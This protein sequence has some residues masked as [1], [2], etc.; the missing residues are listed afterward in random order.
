MQAKCLHDWIPCLKLH[1]S[2]PCPKLEGQCH[3]IFDFPFGQQSSSPAWCSDSQAIKYC[4]EIVTLD[5]S[6][7]KKG[8]RCRSHTNE[9]QSG[10][11]TGCALNYALFP[12]VAALIM[13]FSHWMRAWLGITLIGWELVYALFSLVES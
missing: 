12:L 3:K 10:S 7:G 11:N 8:M 6:F 13:H 2:I 1:D 5:L 9:K 4:S